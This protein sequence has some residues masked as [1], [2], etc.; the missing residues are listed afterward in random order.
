M[1]LSFLL[2]GFSLFR[3]VFIQLYFTE[4]TTNMVCANIVDRSR[5]FPSS[6]EDFDSDDDGAVLIIVP[7]TDLDE[8]DDGSD[9]AAWV[10]R[11]EP[12]DGFVP[13]LQRLWRNMPIR[14]RGRIF[15][16]HL[17]P[18]LRE[19]EEGGRARAQIRR[20]L[21]QMRLVGRSNNE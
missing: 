8:V 10:P 15:D 21:Y 9:H 13:L 7:Q 5:Y 3:V 17:R 14:L 4:Y 2:A 1:S 6:E 19:F 20:A 18:S 12:P 16:D 11:Y